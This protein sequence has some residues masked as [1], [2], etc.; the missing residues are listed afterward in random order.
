[1]AG[2]P[3]GCRA[4]AESAGADAVWA[5]G[6]RSTGDR[7]WLRGAQYDSD[8][9]L[10]VCE[11]RHDRSGCRGRG[12]R[13]RRVGGPDRRECH[14]F[15]R[16]N[17][18]AVIDAFGRTNPD[19]DGHPERHPNDDV[20]S[21]GYGNP[22]AH[23]H[24]HCDCDSDSDGNSHA[25]CHDNSDCSNHV[26]SG[27]DADR[28]TEPNR[29]RHG[30]RDPR[31][32]LDLGAD[33][34]CDRNSNSDGDGHADRNGADRN[35]HT[36]LRTNTDF[37]PDLYV[38]RQRNSDGY[39]DHDTDLHPNGDGNS[40]GN[41]HT[42]QYRAAD[43]SSDSV[44]DVDPE[45]YAGHADS[46]LDFY[47]NP[48]CAADLYPN[49]HGGSDGYANGDAD[50]H[51]KRDANSAGDAHADQYDVVDRHCDSHIDFHGTV[52][53]DVDGISIHADRDADSAGDL[54]ANRHDA[55]DRHAAS[56]GNRHPDPD[57]KR[58][59]NRSDNPH[60]NGSAD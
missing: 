22:D 5:A 55:A 42:D 1:M 35:E 27:A 30:N 14:L 26:E 33:V 10:R 48:G 20:D 18:Y 19:T 46:H 50:L 11:L 58:D 9:A 12:E 36:E 16:I 40:A 56:A 37:H 43:R 49:R 4:A 45:S 3:G 57:T 32:D 15:G 29:H 39:A 59:A 44:G 6:R 54:D 24:V 23:A 31:R 51:S 17:A 41:V 2:E 7:D 47:S 53:T 38:S 8:L 60:T 34:D 28:D 52:H 21:A 13:W 25:H